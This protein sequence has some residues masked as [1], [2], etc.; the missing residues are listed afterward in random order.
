MRY[1]S[2][3]YGTFSISDKFSLIAGFDCGWQQQ[4]KGSSKLNS[5]YAP[6]VIGRYAFTDKI[7]VAGRVEY[8]NDAEGVI[9]SNGLKTMGYSLNLDISPVNNVLFR[10]EGRTFDSKDKIFLNGNT[11][12]A[13]TASLS[14]WF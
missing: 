6:A 2:D 4:F 14:V 5:W 1:F 12:T 3:L 13:L 11:N 7:A 8:Y 10:L 9:I